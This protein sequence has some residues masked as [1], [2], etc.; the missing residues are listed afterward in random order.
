MQRLHVV[1]FTDD[2]EGL[3]LSARRGT[4]TGGWTVAVDADFE[5]AVAELL[6]VR[7]GEA[8]SRIP[9]AESQLSVR[10][11]Q[12]RLRSG[13]SIRQVARAAGVHDEW[14]ERF[15]VPIQ[16]EQNQVVRRAFDLVFTKARNGASSQPLGMAVWWN[17]QDRSVVLP[18]DGW[19]EGW[20]SFLMRDQRWV[21]KFE[22]EHRKRRQ[23]A[24]WDVDLKTGV[25]SSRN[26]LATEL[27]YVEPGRRRRPGPPP[28]VPG[29][30]VTR[31]APVAEVPAPVVEAV[32]DEAPVA[33]R[34]KKRAPKKKAVAKKAVAKKAPARKPVV[35]KVAARKTAAK[36]AP[37]AKQNVVKQAAGAKAPVRKAPIKSAPPVTAKKNVVKKAP[38]VTTAP[39]R[40]APLPAARVVASGVAAPRSVPLTP[41]PAPANKRRGILRRTR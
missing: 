6:K 37:A 32:G 8:E 2:H 40:P 24:E 21:V 20:T 38:P 29:G 39:V 28:P 36:K 14:V 22:Y 26:R 7:G 17:L 11:I 34:K 41:P 3:I 15:A 1:G 30:L 9:R 19:D 31:A 35:K 23:V 5:E 25:L 13:Q 33:P 4:K 12:Q 27:A 18:D 16:A 10:E